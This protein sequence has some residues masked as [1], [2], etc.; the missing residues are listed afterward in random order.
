MKKFVKNN[1]KALYILIAVIFIG[2]I[3][4]T[5]AAVAN[6]LNVNVSKGTYNVVYS[7]TATLPTSKLQPVVDANLLD[8]SNASKVMKIDFT[9]KGAETNPTTKKIIYDVSL[10]NLNLT[11][12]MQHRLLKWRL[13][14]NGSLLSEGNFSKD[15]DF[16]VNSRMVLT[17]TQQDL[18][19]YSSTAD[20]YSFYVWLSEECSGDITTCTPDQD[21]S[22]L[23]D[24]TISGEI[25]IE[26]STGSKKKLNRP[27]MASNK[28]MSL[29]SSDACAEGGTGVCATNSFETTNGTEYHDY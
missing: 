14:K 6:F 24:K 26:L 19:N 22:E 12:G 7:G 3:G 16:Q 10:T 4:V 28:V 13:Y 29:A 15:F 25:R 5:F 11:E 21:I 17:E 9:V 23:L 18:P 1:I 27:Q 2:L 20:S 8:T